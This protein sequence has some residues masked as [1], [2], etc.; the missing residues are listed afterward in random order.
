[1]L[2]AKLYR[3]I[4]NAP[5]ILFRILF[6]ALLSWQVLDYMRSGFIKANF[7]TPAF[8][9]SHIGMEWLQPLAGDGMYYYFGLIGLTS[10]FVMIGFK[11]R[12]NIILFTIVW[13]GMYFMQKTTYNNHH[14]LI[15]LIGFLMCFLPAADY[16]SVDTLVNPNK[17]RLS[18]PYWCSGIMILQIAMVYFFASIAKLYGGWLDGTFLKN[19][20]LN[21]APTFLR[22]IY[23]Q[24]WF[25]LTVA[26]CGLLFDFLIVPLLLWKKTRNIA[27][28][29]SIAFHIFNKLHLSIGIF[30]FLSLS[31]IAFFY[32]PETIRSVFFWKKPPFVTP[33]KPPQNALLYFIFI[34]YFLI[35]LLLP[36]RHH[37]IKGDVFWTE[38]GHRLSWR[39]ML[40]G[41][42]GTTEF[43][44]IDN[45][46]KQEIKYD[47]KKELTKKQIKSM[48]TKPD[49]IWQTAQRIR[50]SFADKGIDVS[51]YANSMVSINRQNEKRKLIDPNVDLGKAKW[52]YFWHNEWILLYDAD[53]E[54]LT[55]TIEYTNDELP[56]TN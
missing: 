55:Q 37:F 38:E 32:P 30:P 54:I 44:V 56:I 52:D 31:F 14:Y 5:L 21:H 12:F 2:K 13:A 1:M 53:G 36:I 17:K 26:Y 19:L 51:V 25:Y 23:A 10:F 49:M 18:M 20:L 28:V 6:G 33:E 16:A 24:P 43:K 40:R 46:T 45:Q 48:Q 4:D 42:S 8:S 34:P 41:R 11:Y 3:P 35:Q 47:L 50:K 39:M 22:G 9:F 27:F 7:I 15:L 29:A